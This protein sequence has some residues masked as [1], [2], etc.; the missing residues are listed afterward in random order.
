[1]ADADFGRNRFDKAL[2]VN[3]N[4]FWLQPAAELE[5]LRKVLR[6]KGVACLVYQL[7]VASKMERVTQAC[8]RFLREHG[9]SGIQ[10][11]IKELRPVPAVCISARAGAI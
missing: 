8:S 3:V 11:S 6:P 7:P 9:F 1:L 4:V 5:V 10:V 2:A